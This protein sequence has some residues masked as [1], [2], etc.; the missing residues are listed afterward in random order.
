MLPLC[1]CTAFGLALVAAGRRDLSLS[2]TAGRSM[3]QI[4]IEDLPCACMEDPPVGMS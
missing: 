2:A 4:Q 3:Q 1:S